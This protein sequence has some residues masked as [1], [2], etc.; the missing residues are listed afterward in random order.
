MPSKALI[1][2]YITNNEE[3]DLYVVNYPSEDH[4]LA[5]SHRVK[6]ARRCSISMLVPVFD[7]KVHVLEVPVRNMVQSNLG[8]CLLLFVMSSTMHITLTSQNR[9]YHARDPSILGYGRTAA[10]GPCPRLQPDMI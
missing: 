7:R 4:C 1:G 9:M 2:A 5:L 3:R 8:S 10:R 6:Y